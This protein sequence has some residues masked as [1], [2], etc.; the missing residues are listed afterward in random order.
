MSQI[1][2]IEK[3]LYQRLAKY[4]NGFETPSQVINKMIDFYETKNNIE[5]SIE[6]VTEKST[7]L[8]IIYYPI[9]DVNNFKQL[10]LEEKMAYINIHKINNETKIIEWNAYRFKDSSD[11]EKNLRSGYLRDWKDKGIFKAELSINKDD[12]V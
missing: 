3:N 2:R 12:F 10:L 1:I 7:N 4:S 9:N 6:L 8:E 5:P 11:I